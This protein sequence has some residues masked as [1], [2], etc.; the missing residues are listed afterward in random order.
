MYKNVVL[1]V[2]IIAIEINFFK[3]YLLNFKYR[4]FFIPSKVFDKNIFISLK[5]RGEYMSSDV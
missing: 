2:F 3:F 4:S 5:L 1:N